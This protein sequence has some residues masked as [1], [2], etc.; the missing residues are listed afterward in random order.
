MTCCLSRA[1]GQNSI[2][3]KQLSDNQLTKDNSCISQH[4]PHPRC[5]LLLS[6]VDS[7]V[8]PIKNVAVFDGH[9]AAS[10]PEY[11]FPIME[12]NRGILQKQIPPASFVPIR[13]VQLMHVTESDTCA[14]CALWHLEQRMSHLTHVCSSVVL[15][16]LIPTNWPH[17]VLAS[18]IYHDESHPPSD[19][20]KGQTPIC[21]L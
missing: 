13:S 20:S 12:A 17:S 8:C 11:L 6:L 15:I 2:F 10:A 16:F 14:T 1:I 5:P 4:L 3:P 21:R 9:H 7:S 19:G 18:L